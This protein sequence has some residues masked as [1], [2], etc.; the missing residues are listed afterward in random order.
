[1]NTILS[2]WWCLLSEGSILGIFVSHKPWRC[3]YGE[4]SAIK[5]LNSSFVWPQV[6]TLVK[7][8]I[9]AKITVKSNGFEKCVVGLMDV[10]NKKK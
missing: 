7:I 10:A 3:F 8:I 9:V 5:N 4:L 1:M 6:Y 2:V